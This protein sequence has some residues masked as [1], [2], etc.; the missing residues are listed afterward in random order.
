MHKGIGCPKFV[1]EHLP[2]DWKD[3]IFKKNTGVVGETTLMQTNLLLALSYSGRLV[4]ILLD[5]VSILMGPCYFKIANLHPYSKN[6][7]GILQ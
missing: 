1:V 6:L 4:E 7:E 2:H 3:Y 5:K